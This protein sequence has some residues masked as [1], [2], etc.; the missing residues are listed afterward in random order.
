MG[1]VKK[2]EETTAAFKKE[3]KKKQIPDTPKPRV[4]SY[5]REHLKLK[6]EKIIWCC[7]NAKTLQIETQ[8]HKRIITKAAAG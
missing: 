2:T 5:K 1:R 4:T 3:K 7:N 8:M 6:L